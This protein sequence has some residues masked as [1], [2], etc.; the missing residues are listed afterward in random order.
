MNKEAL[1]NTHLILEVG[2]QFNCVAKQYGGS[3]S[4]WIPNGDY[5]P[6]EYDVTKDKLFA[7]CC[8]PMPM[9]VKT[10]PTQ[11]IDCHINNL[12]IYSRTK[13][14]QREPVWLSPLIINP[15]EN[16]VEDPA[17]EHVDHPTQQPEEK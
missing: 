12:E 1:I 10:I 2:W 3:Q 7:K 14:V 11:L 9:E 6:L 4:I 5:I 15:A 16:T 17:L 8:N 13:L